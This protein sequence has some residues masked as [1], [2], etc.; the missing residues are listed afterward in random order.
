MEII[1]MKKVIFLVS[2]SLRSFKDNLRYLPN[3]CDIAVYTAYKEDDTYLNITDTDFLFKDSRIKKIIFEQDSIVPSCFKTY[4]QQNMYKQWH[5]L[6]QLFKSVSSDY[7]IYVRMRP[8]IKINNIHQLEELLTISTDSI[9]IPFGNDRNGINDQVCIASYEGMKHYCDIIDLLTPSE[10]SPAERL[11][12]CTSEEILKSHLTFP[13]ERCNLDYSLILSNPKIIS[14]SG[15]SGSGKTTLCK[16]IRPLFIFDNVLEYETDRYHRWERND[17][18]WKILSHLNPES[19]YLEKLEED[20]FNLKC[21]NTILSVDY[22][23]STGKFTS[24]QQIESKDN[25]LLCGLH[26]FYSKN[27]R[28]LSDIKIFMDTDLELKTSWKINRDVYERGHD[29][30]TVLESIKNR[31]K[32]Y[33]NFILPQR[34]FA[35]LVITFCKEGLILY[36]RKQLQYECIKSLRCKITKE[37][38]ELILTFTDPNVCMKHEIELFMR[39][40]S[41]PLFETEY[42]YTSVIQFII[43]NLLYI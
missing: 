6:S 34:E 9:Q 22:D 43:L 20:T 2:G 42:G 13:I 27:L 24:P 5:K 1:T 4:R 25:I 18:H 15:D 29:M 37:P 19:N 32:D 14:I 30:K 40:R 35:D 3:S 39:E 11:A 31:K 17:P 12:E 23:H 36:V 21:G 8:D 7:D 41:L 16:I 28:D 33:E 10:G 38:R 26:T